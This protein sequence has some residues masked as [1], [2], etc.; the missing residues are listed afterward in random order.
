MS[1]THSGREVAQRT[2]ATEFADATHG[3]TESDE[4]RAPNYQL[5]PTGQRAN[6]VFV[7]GTLTETENIGTDSDY[8]QARVVDPTGTFFVY[9]G[10]YQPDAM[11]FLEESE[12]PAYVSVVGKPTTYETE[13]DDGDMETYVS[14]R[15]EDLRVVDEATRDQWVEETAEHTLD[16]VTTFIDDD[17]DSSDGAGDVELAIEEYGE[18]VESYHQGA[19]NALQSLLDADSEA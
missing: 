19:I 12:P 5:L 13:T 17:A 8:W 15:P 3:F 7:V 16:R 10:Q 1:A 9:A 18:D 4:E 11:A 6:R 2:F 14:I